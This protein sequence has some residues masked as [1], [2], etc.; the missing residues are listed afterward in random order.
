MQKIV[1]RNPSSND[2]LLPIV[3]RCNG[4]ERNQYRHV[5]RWVN[6]QL[7]QL[8]ETMRLP[9][10]LTMYVARHSWASIARSLNIPIDVIRLGMGHNSARTTQIYLKEIDNGG[11]DRANRTVM[12]CVAA[13]DSSEKG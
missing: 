12:E 2:Y 7:H 1:D 6:E 8:A 11:I 3:R 5:Q 13:C 10:Q 4:K 9:V